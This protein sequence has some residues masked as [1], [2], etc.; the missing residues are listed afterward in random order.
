MEEKETQINLFDKLSEMGHENLVFC[1]DEDSGLKAI[2]GVHNTVLGPS[3]GGLRM[4]PYRNEQDAIQDVLRLSRGM[5]YKSSISGINLGGGKAVI[6][7]DPKT[8]KTETLFRRFGRFVDSLGGKYITAED[9]GIG[10]KDLEYVGLETEHVTGLPDYLGGSGD[11]S[12]FTAY[13]VFLGMKACAKEVYGSDSLEGKK[14]LVQG[15]GHVGEYLVKHLSESGAKVMINDIDQDRLAEVSK[16]YKSEV[17]PMDGLYGLDMDI[18]SPCALGATLNDQS[19]PQLKC[20]IVAGAANNQL[21]NEIIHAQQLKEKGILYAPDFLINAGGVINIYVEIEG[22]HEGRAKAMCDKIYD[23][24]LEIIE[25]AQKE[26]ITTH[27]AAMK[28]A[29]ERIDAMVKL[30][31]RI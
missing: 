28:I 31:A 2:I 19:I 30:Q 10:P 13:G 20:D 17:V 6:I 24:T 9:V 11:P 3:L 7:A 18:Y 15:I 8:Q 25:T 12:P 22:Y 16:K 1:Q 29:K 5:T 26:N 4:Y 21:K 27:Q 14:V 23:R